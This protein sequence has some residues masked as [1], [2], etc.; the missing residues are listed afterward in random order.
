MEPTAELQTISAARF[1][2]YDGALDKAEMILLNLR[3]KSDVYLRPGM[4]AELRL[5][6][7]ILNL[8]QGRWNASADDFRRAEVMAR[9]AGHAETAGF[10]L[11]WKA[12][13]AFNVGDVVDSAQLAVDAAR[14]VVHG[15]PEFRYRFC[16]VIAQ[17]LSY[18]GD[19]TGAKSWF[20]SAREVAGKL[21]SRGLF[22]ATLFNH[23]AMFAWESL[24]SRRV[25]GLKGAE[26]SVALSAFADAAANYDQ[27]TGVR[28][29][30]FLHDLLRAQILGCSGRPS[31][32]MTVLEILANDHPDLGQYE[33]SKIDLERAWN[34]SLIGLDARLRED[35]VNL[36]ERC[37]QYLADDDELSLAHHLLAKL[38]T[39]A[40]D[41]VAE[42][43]HSELSRKY[44]A[45][46]SER[47]RRV[48]SILDPSL[49][50]L[51]S[52]LCH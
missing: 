40:G 38:A 35:V 32:A 43:S 10:A 1:L 50:P 29:K 30:S 52:A 12:H 46:L 21:G 25:P 5:A 20:D 7:G 24:L 4:V 31:E 47:R 16:Q 45:A 14:S 11:S 26:Q 28:N 34:L 18:S 39:E 6:S 51:P 42:A 15:R 49:L 44:E 33:S 48:L 17:L 19:L 3:S 9:I 23:F 8:F 36:L 2:V 37:L 22:S 41:V 27:M 13:C